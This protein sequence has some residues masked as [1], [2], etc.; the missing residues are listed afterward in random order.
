MMALPY[1]IAVSDGITI[2][3]IHPPALGEHRAT[4]EAALA[5][6]LSVPNPGG[7][8]QVAPPKVLPSRQ[9]P[10]P[11]TT[12]MMTQGEIARTQGFTGDCCTGCG[13][14]SMRRNGTCLL[15]AECGTTTGCS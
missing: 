8:T 3:T 12:A 7:A 5:A 11:T 13:G 15:C 10:R 14:F 9:H 6:V 1:F 4:V 2:R